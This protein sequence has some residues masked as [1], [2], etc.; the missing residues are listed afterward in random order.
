MSN[1]LASRCCI[2][3]ELPPL[4]LVSFDGGSLFC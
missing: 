3:S 1:F 2:K 4:A